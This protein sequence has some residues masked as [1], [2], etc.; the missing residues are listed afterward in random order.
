M[1]GLQK[2]VHSP[3]PPFSRL[4][5][6]DASGEPLQINDHVLQIENEYYSLV[7]P[8][9]VPQAGETPSQALKNR[10][11]GYVE[12]RAVDVNPYSAIGVNE[13]TA[14]FLEALALYCLLSDSP[15]LLCP[16]QDLIEKT[17]QKWLTVAEHQTQPLLI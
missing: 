8:K 11:V 4:G 6:N 12:L 1:D 5:L 16:E 7:R 9:Q 13:T 10:G 15:E 17:R 2:A 3:Y 14:G